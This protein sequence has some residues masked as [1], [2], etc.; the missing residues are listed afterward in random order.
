MNKP[1]KIHGNCD[2]R[3]PKHTQLI[4][5]ESLKTNHALPTQLLPKTQ[6]TMKSTVLLLLTWLWSISTM[7]ALAQEIDN[8]SA[9]MPNDDPYTA[10]MLVGIGIMD[11]AM[12]ANELSQAAAFFEHMTEERPAD[13]LPPYYAA[14]CYVTMAFIE[15]SSTER[16]AW[17]DQAQTYIDIALRIDTRNPELMVVQAYNYMIRTAIDPQNR[18]EE[19]GTMAVLT[20]EEVQK[21]DPN[22]PRAYY[23]QAQNLFFAT[24]SQG[25]GLGKACPLARTAAQKYQLHPSAPKDI[26]PKWGAAMT[27]YMCQICQQVGQ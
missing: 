3:C 11:K 24:E 15:K 21:I 8:N 26:Q 27:D 13:W 23:L 5:F 17:L 6:L 22:N 16:D 7:T 19:Y 2:K 14:Y 25:G 20:L 12:S 4:G 18:M 1:F 9:A 10:N